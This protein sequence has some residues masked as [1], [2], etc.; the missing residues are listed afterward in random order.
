MKK[1]ILLTIVSLLILSFSACDKGCYNPSLEK[2]SQ[3]TVCTTDCPGV[4]GCDGK[5]YCNECEA[6]KLGVAVD[7]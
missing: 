1:Y 2:A 3:N 6:N 5:T 7:N 4:V